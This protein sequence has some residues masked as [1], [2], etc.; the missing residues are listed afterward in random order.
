MGLVQANAIRLQADSDASECGWFAL[1]ELPVLAFDHEDI[2]A[3]A[4][5]KLQKILATQPF[6]LELLEES[7]T[8]ENLVNLYQQILGKLPNSQKLLEKFLSIGLIEEINHTDY[9]NLS[10]AN[11]YHFNKTQYDYYKKNG[12][13]ALA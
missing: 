3:A 2:I 1:S 4:L 13:N 5:A 8:F 10:P 6:G 11:Y 7:F 9:R 12:L